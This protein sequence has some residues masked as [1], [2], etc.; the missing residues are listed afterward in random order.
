MKCSKL[1]ID[2]GLSLVAGG[3]AADLA[4]DTKPVTYVE[5]VPDFGSDLVAIAMAAQIR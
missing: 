2:S 4:A 5:L 3:I 1:G